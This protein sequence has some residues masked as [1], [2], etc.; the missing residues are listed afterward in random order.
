MPSGRTTTARNISAQMNGKWDVT[1]VTPLIVQ[2]FI[3]LSKPVRESLFA[4]LQQQ[5]AALNTQKG[6]L[7]RASLKGDGLAN[8]LAKLQTATAIALQ[9]INQ[10]LKIIPLDT[11]IKEIPGAEE[12]IGETY[13]D[14]KDELTFDT[15]TDTLARIF[16]DFAAFIE[17]L[18][19]FIPVK[20]ALGAISN[21]FGSNYEFFDGVSNFQD[22]RERTEDLEFRLA[23][24]TA[25]SSYAQAGS[26]Y[27]DIQIRKVDVYL[28]IIATLNTSNI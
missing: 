11:I 7:V 26:S 3:V 1:F 4:F 16:P 23:R 13:D 8:E 9:P 17:S 15:F 20:I 6:K 18:T 27:I 24:V 2:I 5:R 12:I 22:L 10:L 19:K 28:D 25:L 14:I 21:T